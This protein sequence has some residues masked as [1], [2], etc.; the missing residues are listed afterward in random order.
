S[1]TATLP[2]PTIIRLLEREFKG[3]RKAGI[4]LGEQALAEGSVAVVMPFLWKGCC[5]GVFKLLKPGIEDRLAEDL[6]IWPMLGEF[7]DEDCARYHLPT[8]DYRETFQT[9]RDLL[10]HE[11]RLDEEQRHLTSAA[12]EYKGMVAVEIP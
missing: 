12:K 8:L 6:A 2:R 9:V 3:W 5:D 10:V 4:H 7:L 11:V 1:L